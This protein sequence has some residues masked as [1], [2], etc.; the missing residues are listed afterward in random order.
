MN[1]QVRQVRQV[2]QGGEMEEVIWGSGRYFF[3]CTAEAQ[4]TQR[5]GRISGY[6]KKYGFLAAID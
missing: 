5:R 1:R 3:E 2:R 4:R 6:I